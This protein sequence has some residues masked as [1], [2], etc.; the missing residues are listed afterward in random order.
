MKRKPGVTA[1]FLTPHASVASFHSRRQPSHYFSAR[2]LTNSRK[3]ESQL[4]LRDLRSVGSVLWWEHLNCLLIYNDVVLHMFGFAASVNVCVRA[5][6]SVCVDVRSYFYFWVSQVSNVQAACN[7]CKC[8]P[9]TS[10]REMHSGRRKN[11]NTRKA[12][13]ARQLQQTT[14]E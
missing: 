11:V 2:G 1:A 6:V 3:M 12:I 10:S 5:S 9:V 14:D 4:V 8:R 13:K 7:A